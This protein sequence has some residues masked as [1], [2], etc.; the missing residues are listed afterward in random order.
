M[1]KIDHLICHTYYLGHYSSLIKSCEGES[2]YKNEFCVKLGC[3]WERSVVCTCTAPQPE[4]LQQHYYF[5]VTPFISVFICACTT[6]S[7]QPISMV[8]GMFNLFFFS[9]YCVPERKFAD[10]YAYVSCQ[11]LIEKSW[12]HSK[13]LGLPQNHILCK[14][15]SPEFLTYYS[16]N[17]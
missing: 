4:D 13:M 15:G 12:L 9:F 1:C 11:N 3:V 5:F 16:M 2:I 17:S 10:K 14:V 7:L 6:L 8:F